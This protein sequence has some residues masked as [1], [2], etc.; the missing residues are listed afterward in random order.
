MTTQEIANRL[1]ELCSKGDYSTCYEELY[2]PEIKSIE[3]DGSVVNGFDGI[4]QK[5]KEWNANI[6]EF[7]GSGIGEPIVSGNWFS[8]P[9][10]MTIKRKGA[11]EAIKFEE[12]C[13]YQ[14]KDGK[15]VQEQFF[16][17]QA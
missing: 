4:A 15:I 12:I 2:S 5:G 17:D 11:P 1:V 7:L 16:Y 3:A 9:M 6:E 14:V 13:V 10:H 8:L